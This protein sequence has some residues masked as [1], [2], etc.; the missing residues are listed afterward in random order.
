MNGSWLGNERGRG[1]GSD[2]GR[3]TGIFK[4]QRD[5]VQFKELKEDCQR[6]VRQTGSYLKAT[7]SQAQVVGFHPWG[8]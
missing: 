1:R 4:S 2:V 8:N 7:V 3:G 5:C 6:L